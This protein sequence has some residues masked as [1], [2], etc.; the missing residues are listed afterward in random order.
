VPRQ[1]T[2]EAE[3]TQQ[4]LNALAVTAPDLP[5][6]HHHLYRCPQCGDI[7]D[8]RELGDVLLHEEPH[9]SP[10]EVGPEPFSFVE[11]MLPTLVMEPP[12]GDEW[13]H[14]I[15]Y[16]GYRTQIIIDG[17]GVRAYTRNGFDW[18]DRYKNV[19]AAADYLKCGSAILDGEMIVQDEHGRSDFGGFKRA[20]T[21]EPERLVFMGFDL[22]RLDGEDLRNM[23]L[24]ERRTRLRELVGCHDP[25]CRIQYSE[26]VSGA[27]APLFEA[28][29]QM[30]L[31]GIVSKKASSRY[32][33]G[34]SRAWL[35]VKCWAEDEFVVTGVEPAKDGPAM[36]IL[37]RCNGEALTPAGAAAVTLAGAERERF[38]SAVEELRVNGTAPLAHPTHQMRVRARFLKGGDKLRHA[39]LRALI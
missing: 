31:E 1:R 29:D 21:Q 13:I 28:A 34:R 14:E 39:T 23:P 22:L 16:D 37:A 33:S 18:T 38:W 11:P 25:G 27:G 36:A 26:H 8:R 5:S 30:G 9:T 20:L 7:I 19:L 3:L 2:K 24:L 10:D 17:S 12:G 6:D 35:K 32:R 15:K 4:E